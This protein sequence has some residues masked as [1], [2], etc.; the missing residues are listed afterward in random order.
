MLSIPASSSAS[1]TAFS[2]SSSSFSAVVSLETVISFS[3]SSA[4]FLAAS[5]FSSGVAGSLSI[6]LFTDIVSDT[7]PLSIF[8]VAL[9]LPGASPVA[10]VFVKS[11][12]VTVTSLLSMPASSSASFTAS[13]ILSFSFSSVVPLETVISFSASSAAFLAASTFS[14]GVLGSLSIGWF[15]DI[16]S[17]TPPLSIFTVA[18]TLPGAVS[19]ASV[20]V[21]S[22]TVTVTSLLSMPASSSASLTASSNLSFS[23]SSV[24]PL[25]TV[26][27]FS[28]SSAAFLAASTFSSGVPGS[29]PIGLFTDIVSDTP[30]LSIFT[31]APIL[32]G[33]SPVASVFVKSSTVTVTSLLS[34]PASSSA[35]L[36]A[37][38]ILSFSFS[39]VVPLETVISFSAS[40]A[41]F[42][43][44]STFSSGVAGSLSIGL[45]TGILPDTPPL[46]ISTVA[47]MLP[48]ASSVASIFVKSLT[49]TITSVLS[50]PASA[51]ASLTAFSILSCSFSAVVPLETVISFSASSAAFFAASTFSAPVPGSLSIGWFTDTV[52]DT[53]PL[54]IFTV[55]L[56][57]P[58]ASPVASV[59]VKSSTVTVTS[60]LSTPASVSASFTASS[61]LSFSFSSVVPLE[62]VISFSASSTAFLAASTFSSGVAGSLSIGLF[63]G[64]VSDTPPLSIFTV[65][66][67]LPGASSVASVFVKSSTVTVTFLL[68]M[69]ASASASLT[70]SSILSFS[71][72][73]VV[74]LENVIFSSASSAAF[75]AV[76][77]VP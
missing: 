33:V 1:L 39:S 47:L 50:I 76:S 31:V 61:I 60:L 59:F 10:S 4:I 14:S 28:A 73:A 64:M 52:S 70:A 20:F 53:P 26:I 49:P 41:A 40:S 75:F 34:M 63:T 54:S 21:K 68:S 38:C 65:A 55:A 24:V 69:P 2:I 48:A 45:F 19:V 15:T 43:A 51:S 17:D 57:L 3:A 25:E 71:F 9:T 56:M 22:S 42:L 62:T 72:S 32:P 18:L 13:S 35:S 16:V 8:T 23:F 6:G 5:T 29:L 11:S 46:T 30:P 12:T 7:P 67:T 44:A 77:T 66:L 58:G 36:T 37:S 74:P 27:S